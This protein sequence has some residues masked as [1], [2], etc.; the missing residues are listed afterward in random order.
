[1][2]KKDLSSPAVRIVENFIDDSTCDYL[3]DYAQSEN[4]WDNFNDSITPMAFKN[5]EEYVSAGKQWNNRRIDINELYAQGMENRKELF[6]IVLP[7]Q[8]QMHSEVLDFLKPGFDLYSELW[9]IVRWKEGNF[10]EPHVDHIDP[11]FDLSSVNLDL[12]PEECK[13]FFEERNIEKYKKLFTNKAFTSII[14][15]N[16]NYE[17][18]EL[19]FPQHNG[20]KIKPKKGTMLI[21]SGTIDNMHGIKEVTSGTRY[22]HVT[23]WSNNISKSSKIAFDKKVDRLLVDENNKPIMS[24]SPTK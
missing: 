18:G 10:Q 9:E 17:G 19:Y 5:K 7:L 3:I 15:L 21:F 12:V 1:M 14:Y 16:D 2:Y 4:L 6:D 20:F 22:T 23:F 24:V 13:Y 11:D 8:Y